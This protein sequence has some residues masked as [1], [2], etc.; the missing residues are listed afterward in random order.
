MSQ[1]HCNI[2][3][4]PLSTDRHRSLLR[5]RL[6]H[7]LSV[8]TRGAAAITPLHSFC[9]HPLTC[10]CTQRADETAI[11]SPP[12]HPPLSPLTHRCLHPYPPLCCSSWN[13]HCS[14]SMSAPHPPPPL[15]C[16]YVAAPCS[17]LSP[18]PPLLSSPL[19]TFGCA[20]NSVPLLFPRPSP[21]SIPTARCSTS[22]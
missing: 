18:L 1:R 6:V 2:Y 9:S 3:Q 5:L 8:T 21:G 16:I 15:C 13:P 10:L 12:T 19:T 7:S 4:Q 11:L 22:R 17:L 14:L 20:L